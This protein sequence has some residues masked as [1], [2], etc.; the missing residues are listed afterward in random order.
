MSSAKSQPSLKELVD[1]FYPGGCYGIEWQLS[2]GVLTH[3]EH[4]NPQWRIDAVRAKGLTSLYTELS[5]CYVF[6]VGQGLVGKAFAKQEPLFVPDVQALDTESVMDAM[7][8]GNST[9][10]LRASLAKEFDLRSAFF[11]PVPHGVLEVGSLALMTALPPYFSQY[12][13]HGLLPVADTLPARPTLRA[14]TVLPPTFLQKLVEEL[15]SAGCYGIEWTDH[16]GILTYRSH[17]NPQWR[18]DVLRQVGLSAAYT[19]ES[20]SFTFEYGE[21]LV[22]SAFAKQSVLFTRDV[23]EVSPDDVKAAMQ[24]G[25]GAAFQRADVAKK[26]GIHSV[27][28]LPS[29]H[30]VLEVGSVKTFDNLQAFLSERAAEAV[31]GKTAAADI[32]SVLEALAC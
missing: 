16:G 17:F 27:L 24:S 5:Q 22:G 21:G 11:L 29:A 28:L 13:G 14:S 26:F 19:T 12:G 2:G 15:S 7:Q 31:N 9:E 6:D 32:L 1:N 20:M 18:I 10:F 23:Q 8:G 30:G 25:N 3:K 4:F